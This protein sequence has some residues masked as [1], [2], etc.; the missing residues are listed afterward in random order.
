MS[1]LIKGRLYQSGYPHSILKALQNEF[2]VRCIV[3]CC[4]DNNA[5]YRKELLPTTKM[6]YYPIIDYSIPDMESFRDLIDNLVK[7]YNEGKNIFI[8]CMGGRGRSSIVSICLYGKLFQLSFEESLAA[9]RSKRGKNIPETKEQ[10]EFI[11]Q[12]FD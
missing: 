7:E 9:I 5:F 6:Y 4:D 2:Q 11:K 3:N 12:F 10:E 1:E 8:H